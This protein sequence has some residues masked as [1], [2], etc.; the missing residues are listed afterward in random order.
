MS[1]FLG[2]VTPVGKGARCKR[3]GYTTVGS[4]PILPIFEIK[5]GCSCQVTVNHPSVKEGRWLTSGSI[6]PALIA[7]VLNK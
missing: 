4:I 7:P 2:Q 3:V 5:G 6:P 1:D